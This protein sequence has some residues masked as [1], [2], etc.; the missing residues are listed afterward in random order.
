MKAK[1]TASSLLPCSPL[2]ILRANAKELNAQKGTEQYRALFSPL[3][4][5]LESILKCL[6]RSHG[7][8]VASVPAYTG[9]GKTERDREEG[10]EKE[11]HSA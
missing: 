5:R 10:E 11:K 4:C 7:L 1:E 6:L 3:F 9:G 2:Y 8:F